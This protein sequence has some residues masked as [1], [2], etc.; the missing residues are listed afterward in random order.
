L[1]VHTAKSGLAGT[2]FIPASLPPFSTDT[3]MMELSWITIDYDQLD[4]LTAA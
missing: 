4:R 1:C 2:I 3:S